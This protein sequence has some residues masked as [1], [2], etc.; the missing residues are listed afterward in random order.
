M[1]K[2]AIKVF[3]TPIEGIVEPYAWLNKADTKF[4]ERGEHKVNLTF[5]L[6][7]ERVRKMITVLQKI[8]DDA[9]AKALA[10]HEKNPPQVQRGKKPIEPR[11]GDMPWIENG[12]GTV[13]LKFKCFASYLKDGK[14]EPITLRFYAAK[15]GKLIRDV[16]NIGSG[17]KIKVKFKVL[18]FKWNAATGASVKL[19]LDSVLLVEL[20]E[21]K[22]DGGT[23]G[24]GDDEA[25]GEGYEQSEDG[26]FDGQDFEGEDSEGQDGS[27][28][29]D[30]DF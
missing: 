11:E 19:Q 23:G 20:K 25:I 13:T 7:D 6:S 2:D 3:T 18:P 30:Y 22:G 5:P 21:W 16:P 27:D 1:S 26:N 12:D 4:N 24:W 17:S 14:S 29:G 15:D 28:S 8:H 10:D 9:Y